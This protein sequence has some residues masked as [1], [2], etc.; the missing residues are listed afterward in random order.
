MRDYNITVSGKS[1]NIPYRSTNNESSLVLHGNDS[2]NYGQALLTNL[3]RLTDNFCSAS[4]PT[5]PILGQTYYNYITKKISVYKKNGWSEINLVPNTD[6]LDVVYL[7]ETSKGPHGT[8]ILPEVLNDYIPLSGND[9]PI[10]V[11]TIKT[12]FDISNE[13]VTKAYVD[14]IFREKSTIK[15]LPIAAETATMTGALRLKT[16]Y[17]KDDSRKAV[18]VGYVNELGVLNVTNNPV[19]AAD[20]NFVVTTYNVT[21]RLDD[22]RQPDTTDSFTA[23]YFSALLTNTSLTIPLPVTFITSSNMTSGYDMTVVCKSVDVNVPVY[24]SIANGQSVTIKRKTG[25]S[26]KVD[27]MIFGFTQPLVSVSRDISSIADIN[28]DAALSSKVNPVVATVQTVCCGDTTTPVATTPPEVSTTTTAVT[29]TT[30]VNGTTT[31]TTSTPTTTTTLF[32][33]TTTTSAPTTTTTLFGHTTTTEAPTTTTTE[34]PTT[35]TTAEPTTTTTQ[36]SLPET[37]GNPSLA[38]DGLDVVFVV[39]FTSSMGPSIESVK[40]TI[41]NI[42]D[43]ISSKSNTNYRLGLVLFDETTTFSYG[44][45]ERYLSSTD[46]KSLP[47]SQKFNN[48]SPSQ[49]GRVQMITTME[50][51][52]LNNKSSFITQLNK[53]NTNTFLLGWGCTTPEPGDMALDKTYNN[54][55]GTWRDNVAKTVILITDA[56][57][58]GTTDSNEAADTTAVN[59]LA[60]KYY[61]K[62]IRMSMLTTTEMIANTGA[63]A[64]AKAYFDMVTT[65]GGSVSTPITDASLIIDAIKAIP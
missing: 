3:I 4:A 7:D 1:F 8:N 49:G 40:S 64:G 14:E 35:T 17:R 59:A 55:A 48:S 5:N 31:T 28:A 22:Y 50:M 57:P 36:A 54:F 34:E 51:M 12:A 2:T 37:P 42:V 46:Y 53:I 30:T 23:I 24:A 56:P 62:N 43:T 6:Y 29:S 19:I 44:K 58:S 47:A 41:S 52:Q 15:Y 60:T 26:V 20:Y 9:T 65:T 45:L 39:D 25:S 27:G 10:S 13:A 21:G 18:T 11:S 61:D 63:T 38:K 32:G 16:P 33:H